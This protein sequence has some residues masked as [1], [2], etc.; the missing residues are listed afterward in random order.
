MRIHFIQHVPFE[1]PAA[2]ADWARQHQH[3]TTITRLYDGE[4]LPTMEAFDWLVIM[5]GPM[6]VA[7]TGQYAWL[8][9]EKAF[10][11]Q[12][13]SVGKTVLG[14]CLGAQLIAAALGAAVKK[15][16]HREI[17]WFP[18]SPA[19][20]LRNTILDGVFSDNTLAFHWHGDTFDL[21]EQATLIASSK[22]CRNQGFVLN[23]HVVGLQFHLETTPESARAL[24]ENGR[25]ELDGSRFVQ[26]EQEML[27]QPERFETINQTLFSLLTRL[28]KATTD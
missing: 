9:N 26:T 12:T 4:M 15:N 7:D 28:E 11:G 20:A 16:P 23:D 19:D 2:I 21:P 6:G 3:T 18:L 5:G 10:I 13:V 1:G 8:E 17:G 22:A 14:I 24:I 27:S 25:D